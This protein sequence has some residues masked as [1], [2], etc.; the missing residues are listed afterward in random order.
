MNNE[1]EPGK[2]IMAFRQKMNSKQKLYE[3]LD[4]V[5]Q[6]IEYENVEL[7]FHSQN[8]E[9][10]IFLVR[11]KD[12]HPPAVF[13]AIEKIAMY[14][15]IDYVEADYIENK[16]LNANDPLYS[17]LWGI[18]KIKAPLAWNYTTGSQEVVVGIID[19]GIDDSHPDIRRNMWQSPQGRIVNGWNFADDNQFSMDVD[20]HGTHVAGTVGAVGNNY[21]GITGV[22]WNV[23][24]VSMKFGLDVASAI[25]A[26]DFANVFHIPILNA[27]WGGRV[28]SLALKQAINQY[29]GLFIASAGNNGENNDIY[30]IYPATYE[31]AN[32]ISVA[33]I[34]PSNEL[35]GFSNY[36]LK[37]VDIAA[38]G[39]SILSL[40]L[41]GGYSP[42]NGT[43][44]AAPHVAGAAALL[45]SYFPSLSPL[46]IKNII[47]D[48][49]TKLPQLKNTIKT[50]GLLNLEAMFEGAKQQMR[51]RIE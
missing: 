13:D 51:Q 1:Y 21:I 8:D 6:D 30:P 7:I 5:L 16:H 26:I 15:D 33:A 3:S 48:N 42:L 29:D 24:V 39:T 4:V 23:K 25:A 43:S 17:Q 34:S 32:I 10:D 49:V 37:S 22:C 45:K 14:P 44:M 40:D 20:G 2:V 12:K 38:P 36:G 35:A 50:S 46:A 41:Q 11:L 31:S 28:Y 27:S 18:Q 47:L 19:T 9:G